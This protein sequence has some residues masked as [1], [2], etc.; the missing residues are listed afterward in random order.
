[1]I[2]ELQKIVKR[3]P[4]NIMQP[5]VLDGLDLA[6]GKGERLAVTGPSGC[7]KSTLLNIAGTLD[8]PDAGN[9]RFDNEDISN[10]PADAIS[11]I[12]NRKIGFV[13][14]KHFLLPQLNV[15]ENVLLPTIP[16]KDINR[17]MALKNAYELLDI[18]GLRD[19]EKKF[20]AHL[21]VGECQRVA[22]VRAMI[23]NPEIILADEPTGALDKDSAS[24]VGEL[25]MA[26]N[27]D[28]GVS[29][30]VVTHSQELASKIGVVNRLL[31]GKLT[32]N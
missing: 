13:F 30:L 22:I 10:Y 12:R 3:Y 24:K 17:S 1:M 9:V 27:K 29:L 23:N 11:E 15:I 2:I 19:K 21:S 6:M 8:R 31:S 5:N 4:E 18:V 28:K 7:G 32:T 26:L 14:Q 20:P 25:L 16:M